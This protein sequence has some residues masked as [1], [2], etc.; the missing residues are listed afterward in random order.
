MKEDKGELNKVCTD[1]AGPSI[2]WWWGCLPSSWYKRHLS[3]E[4]NPALR[5]KKEGQ[6]ALFHLLCLICLYLKTINTQSSEFRA[7]VL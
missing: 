7:A 6:G 1:F 4:I 3:T 2:I 5:N